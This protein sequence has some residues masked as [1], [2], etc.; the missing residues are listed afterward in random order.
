M[1]ML[2]IDVQK[3]EIRLDG[4]QQLFA[5]PESAACGRRLKTIFAPSIPPE[6]SRAGLHAIKTLG[7][8]GVGIHKCKWHGRII[9]GQ[10][11]EPLR[12]RQIGRR[13]D[14]VKVWD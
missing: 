1:F 14:G 3:D 5:R 10:E 2:R 9:G 7:R 6:T 11:R 13:A 4:L 12:V 8:G